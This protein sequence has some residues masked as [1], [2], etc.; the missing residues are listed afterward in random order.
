MIFFC[1]IFRFFPANEISKPVL[2]VAESS[3]S[4]QEES[5]EEVDEEYRGSLLFLTELSED[6]VA[7]KN[8]VNPPISDVEVNEDFRVKFSRQKQISMASF[9]RKNVLRTLMNSLFLSKL[10]ST[11]KV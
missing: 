8:E 6:R 11:N 1:F 3:R 9:N 2:E 5:D 7:N 10:F 4:D